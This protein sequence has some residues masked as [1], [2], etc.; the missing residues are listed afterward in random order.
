MGCRLSYLQ[1]LLFRC[2]DSHGKIGKLWLDF[3]LAWYY[4]RL[5]LLF[6]D[7]LVLELWLVVVFRRILRRTSFL[8]VVPCRDILLDLLINPLQSLQLLFNHTIMSFFAVFNLGAQSVSNFVLAEKLALAEHLLK[9][10]KS[11]GYLALE[12]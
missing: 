6:L 12:D 5:L 10:V 1:A 8:D 7:L 3:D 4:I 9:L 11:F 2:L